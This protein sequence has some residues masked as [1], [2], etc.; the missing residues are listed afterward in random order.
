MNNQVSRAPCLLQPITSFC[1]LMGLFTSGQ[2]MSL[3]G[4]GRQ[5]QDCDGV[6]PAL[7]MEMSHWGKKNGLQLRPMYGEMNNGWRDGGVERNCNPCL[8]KLKICP[9]PYPCSLSQVTLQNS[10]NMAG[11]FFFFHQKLIWWIRP[12]GIPPLNAW[13][14]PLPVAA[15]ELTSIGGIRKD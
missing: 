8:T 1:C 14:D 7:F 3:A 11:Q 2:V 9:Y 6:P 5:L 13:S 12:T 4:H 15:L 10:Q